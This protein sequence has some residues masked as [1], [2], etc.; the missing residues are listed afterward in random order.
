MRSQKTEDVAQRLGPERL[1]PLGHERAARV[2]ARRD[3]VLLDLDV[4]G[5]AAKRDARGVLARDHAGERLALLRRH[6]PLP[7]AGIDFAVGIDDVRQQLGAAVGAHA[8]QRRTGF[9]LSEVAQLVAR[10][11]RCR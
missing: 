8:V 5:R 2:L 7:E 11:S 3:V 9:A 1:E 4:A 6:V 10:S